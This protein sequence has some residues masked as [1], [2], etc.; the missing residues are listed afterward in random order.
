MLLYR[1]LIKLNIPPLEVDR[2]TMW[3]IGALFDDDGSPASVNVTPFS[4]GGRD[5]YLA[6]RI[7]AAKKGEGVAFVPV[8]PKGLLAGAKPKPQPQVDGE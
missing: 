2:M 3:Q 8:P 7:E 1:E 4:Q 5:P 6:A